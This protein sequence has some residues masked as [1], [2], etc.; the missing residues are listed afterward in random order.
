M[1][2][3]SPVSNVVLLLTCCQGTLKNTHLMQTLCDAER[4]KK[5]K[6]EG[7]EKHPAV[8]KRL[9]SEARPFYF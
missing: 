1:L 3:Y 7:R 5:E 2:L 8:L 9:R 4:Q 6:S